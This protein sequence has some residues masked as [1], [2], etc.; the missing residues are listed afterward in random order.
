MPTS[1]PVA[2]HPV[3]LH[4]L[5]DR[6]RPSE[7][8][9][10]CLRYFDCGMIPVKATHVI[11]ADR[12][13]TKPLILAFAPP[14]RST[15]R[16]GEEIAQGLREV[17]QSLLLHHLRSITK[18]QVLRPGGRE[19][20]ALL[21]IPRRGTPAGTPPRMLLHG[22]V[23]DVSGVRAVPNQN[24]FLLRGG[25]KTIPRHTNTLTSPDTESMEAA[26]V[27][28]QVAGHLLPASPQ[29]M[30]FTREPR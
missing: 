3:R 19:L 2:G 16:P 20:S 12:Y 11:R 18:P 17:A 26:I 22:K 8:N 23:P 24:R 4:V 14:C 29:G 15:V 13:N 6:T 5:G 28:H 27:S 25:L 21:K 30:D 1:R 7:P 10:S 9:P